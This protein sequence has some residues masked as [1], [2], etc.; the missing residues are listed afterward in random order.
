MLCYQSK[1]DEFVFTVLE[2]FRQIIFQNYST[3][4]RGHHN[5][6]E[7]HLPCVLANWVVFWLVGWYSEIK[8]FKLE[9]KNGLNF[10]SLIR[11]NWT[12]QQWVEGWGWINFSCHSLAEM[13]LTTIGNERYN[14]CK[15]HYKFKLKCNNLLFWERGAREGKWETLSHI[16]SLDKKEKEKGLKRMEFRNIS[17]FTVLINLE[18]TE[19]EN[20]FYQIWK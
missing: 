14:S 19:I 7:Y 12:W 16:S 10:S 18:V 15:R 17:L 6:W 2:T 20:P 9:N 8:N 11:R 1:D 5:I 4:L 3:N 13:S